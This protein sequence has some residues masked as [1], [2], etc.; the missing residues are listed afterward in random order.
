M[1]QEQVW[2]A[3]PPSKRGYDWAT[4]VDQLTSRPGEWLL[5][6]E[7]ATRSLAGAIKRR[8]MR[9]IKDA[10]AAGWELKVTTRNNTTKTAEVWMSAVRREEQ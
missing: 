2:R 5:I 1:T 3:E 4:I 8:K 9:A 7:E 6:N 10:W